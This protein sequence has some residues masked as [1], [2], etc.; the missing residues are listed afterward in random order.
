VDLILPRRVGPSE[1]RFD[2]VA[3]TAFEAA[4][5]DLNGPGAAAVLAGRGR[6]T[7]AGRYFGMA[8]GL[9]L[10]LMWGER[11]AQLDWRTD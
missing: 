11:S 1:A 2:P 4:A 10:A 3:A 9:S 6:P 7:N 8:H 5:A